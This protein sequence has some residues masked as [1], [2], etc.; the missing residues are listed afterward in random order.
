[1][2]HHEELKVL[3]DLDGTIANIEHRLH[4]IRGAEKDWDK[5]FEACSGDSPI[6]DV[7]QV[8]RMLSVSYPITI[9]TSRSDVV[10]ERTQRWLHQHGIPYKDLYMRVE[11]DHTPDYK[12]KKFWAEANIWTK[13]TV[14]CVFEDRDSVVE[15]WRG[16]GI[17]CIQTAQ[18]DF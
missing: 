8:I 3:C 7:V 2:G 17:T 15:M 10:L 14:L 6:D 13:E 11:G 16:L 1:V 18:G 5:F 12:L 4:H 9:V